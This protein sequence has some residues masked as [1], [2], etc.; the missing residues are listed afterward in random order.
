MV[1]DLFLSPSDKKAKK[2]KAKKPKKARK[3]RKDSASDV[4]DSN[5]DDESQEEEDEGMEYLL[6]AEELR[7]RFKTG[8][9]REPEKNKLMLEDLEKKSLYIHELLQ[10]KEEL[11]E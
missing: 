5:L 4:N 8:D 9:L 3:Q 7:E 10:D 11:E 1:Q 2:I 6:S